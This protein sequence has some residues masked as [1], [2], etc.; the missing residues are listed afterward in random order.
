[1][2]LRMWLVVGVAVWCGAE[3]TYA[4][5]GESKESRQG[6]ITGEVAYSDPNAKGRNHQL[7]AQDEL[8]AWSTQID[9]AVKKGGEGTVDDLD[10][11]TTSYLSVLYFYCTTKQGPCAFVLETILDAELIRAKTKK[12]GSCPTMSRFFKSYLANGLDERGKFLYSLTRGLEMATFNAD[13]RPR[14]LECKETVSAI[15]EDKEVV[16]Q[17][18]GEKGASLESVAKFKALVKEVKDTKT[19]IYSAVGLGETKKKVG[20]QQ[21]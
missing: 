17:R 1:M 19:D 10:S 7:E 15:L 11:A 6:I 13:S 4:Q 20:E 9:G 14:F 8:E 2:R 18:F 5:G 3:A 21:P 16:E 12:A